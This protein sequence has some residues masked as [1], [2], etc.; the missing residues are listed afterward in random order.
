MALAAGID[1]AELIPDGSQLFLGFTS[2]QR[3][4]LAPDRI[5]NFETLLG[6][7]DQWPDGYFRGGTVMHLSHLY[8]DVGSWW[9][10]FSHD[11]QTRLMGRP[12]VDL[13]RG[14]FTL[15]QPAREVQTVAEV[16]ADARNGAVGHSGGLQHTTRLDRDVVD[17]Y[18]NVRRKGSTFVHRADFNTLDNPFF[19]SSRPDVD[20]QRPEPAAG[21]HFVAFMPTAAI[22]HKMR[23]AMDG[24]LAD[25]TK[26]GLGQRSRAMGIN[27]VITATHRQNF[28]V[29][30]R[31]ARSF[32]LAERLPRGG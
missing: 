11:E 6:L 21:V 23:Y 22:F 29:P 26:L 12:G 2:T 3:R 20:G 13:P 28:L 8:E 4:A 27:S 31:A 24:E 17:N 15:P 16:A 1:G 7:T 10:G 5:T 9:R 14:R 25:G 30:P 32:P 19:W 18:G